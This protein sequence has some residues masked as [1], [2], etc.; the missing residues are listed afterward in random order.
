ML[1]VQGKRV[2][3]LYALVLFILGGGRWG[4]GCIPWGA[5]VQE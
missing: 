4:G 3:S 1:S 5:S 2:A